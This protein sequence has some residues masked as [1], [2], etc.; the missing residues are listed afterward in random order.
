MAPRQLHAV[1][2]GARRIERVEQ[3]AFLQRRQAVNRLDPSDAPQG[4]ERGLA[5]VGRKRA[6][7][8]REATRAGQAMRDDIV[9]RRRED[10]RE[11]LGGGLRTAPATEFDG[12]LQ[13]TV[14]NVGADLDRMD[15]AGA[16]RYGRAG[17]LLRERDETPVQR[18]EAAEIVEADARAGA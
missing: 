1:L 3:Q 2:V 16:R 7:A 4:V 6:I 5:D 14:G 12:D 10:I 17:L 13:R 18:I 8:R 11:M 9:E 15:K